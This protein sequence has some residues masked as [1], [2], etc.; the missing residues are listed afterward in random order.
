MAEGVARRQD[1]SAQKGVGAYP[2]DCLGAETQG[3][4]GY[5]ISAALMNVPGS[6]GA[7]AIVTNT[8]VSTH[9]HRS[10]PTCRL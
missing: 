3:Q 1:Y 5:V 9:T 4:I 7:C 2:F 8:L 10:C 6:K